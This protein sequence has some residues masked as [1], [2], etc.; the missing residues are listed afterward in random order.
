VW[1]V[2][3]LHRAEDAPVSLLLEVPAHQL[4]REAEE[5]VAARVLNRPA[6]PADRVAGLGHEVGPVRL[7]Q[8]DPAVV[9]DPVV[10]VEHVEE[11]AACDG[12]D[13]LLAALP[14][15]GALDQASDFR[16]AEIGADDGELPAAQVGRGVQLAQVQRQD[17]A[18]VFSRELAQE[19]AGQPAQ[20]TEHRHSDR[21]IGFRWVSN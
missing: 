13:E 7:R 16:G 9:L 1:L 10:L 3:G 6:V 19:P 2:P 11:S 21:P 17:V 20:G 18:G 4:Q 8:P 12:R 5:P 15:Q 14:R